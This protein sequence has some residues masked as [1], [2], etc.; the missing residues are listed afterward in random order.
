MQQT[1]WPLQVNAFLGSIIVFLGLCAVLLYTKPSRNTVW[2]DKGEVSERP[3]WQQQL[4]LWFS[5]K[6]PAL[7]DES[8]PLLLRF[9]RAQ[10]I[11]TQKLSDATSN[12]VKLTLYGFYNQATKGDVE[13]QRPSPYATQ[14][15]EKFEAWERFRGM[16][17]EEAMRGYIDAVSSLP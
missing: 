2:V 10:S 3:Q 14:E 12:N 15:R 4:S 5:G 6:D 8:R 17:Q 9:E 1:D 13:G 16:S 7:H 11:A